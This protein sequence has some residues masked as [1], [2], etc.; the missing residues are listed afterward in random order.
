M[1]A[2]H[3]TVATYVCTSSFRHVPSA[4]CVMLAGRTEQNMC[5]CIVYTGCIEAIQML[6]KTV[7]KSEWWLAVEHEWLHQMFN[8]I[9]WFYVIAEALSSVESFDCHVTSIM[10][11][12]LCGEVQ[13]EAIK[14]NKRSVHEH[15]ASHHLN[16]MQSV[17][18]ISSIYIFSPQPNISA[19]TNQ[20][21]TQKTKQMQLLARHARSIL[22][23]NIRDIINTKAKRSATELQQS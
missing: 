16:G 19:Q 7:G 23:Q 20:L 15:K 21:T 12:A 2:V 3:D 4:G 22:M 11:R 10:V 5:W 18:F 17:Q 14:I 6:P 1:L 9:I 8:T 13:K